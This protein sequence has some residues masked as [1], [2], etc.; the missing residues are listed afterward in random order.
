LTT[1][2]GYFLKGTLDVQTTWLNSPATRTGSYD[3]IGRLTT[4][5]KPGDGLSLSR[6]VA[7]GDFTI[8][9]SQPVVDKAFA[10]QLNAPPGILP[11]GVVSTFGGSIRSSWD[12]NQTVAFRYDTP[13]A[14]FEQDLGQ[15]LTAFDKAADGTET[16][17]FSFDFTRGF[18]TV[19]Q[20]L[21][22]STQLETSLTYDIGYSYVAMGEWTW[23]LVD[24][25]GAPD[26]DFGDLLF[27][28]GDRTPT[29]GIPVSGTATYDAHSF[30]LFGDSGARGIPFTLTADFGQRT[31]STEIDQDYVAPTNGPFGFFAAA[32][33]H[34]S[35]SAPF[36]NS[37]SFNIPLTGTATWDS[38]DNLVPDLPSQPVTGN[39]DGAFFGPHAEQVGGVF[40][41]QTSTGDELLHDA[42]V[43]KQH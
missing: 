11:A 34:V 2:Q 22:P 43:G 38:E 16:Q 8:A 37:G 35:G 9:V 21:N 39:M 31:M 13:Y 36:T 23:K 3:L 18:A 7:P 42:F 17:L 15:R 33:I 26:S 4:D 10:Y 12:I 29:S 27:V 14:D 24:L 19:T 41:L 1:I 40:S 30:A 25:N 20:Q 32:G 28:D 6:D 5:P